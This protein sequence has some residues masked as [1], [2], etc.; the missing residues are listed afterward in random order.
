MERSKQSWLDAHLSST[1][2]I[3]TEI[4]EWGLGYCNVQKKQLK[5]YCSTAIP[6]LFFLTT[7]ILKIHYFYFHDY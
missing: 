4:M 6:F 2:I 1:C 7:D 3:S 5:S